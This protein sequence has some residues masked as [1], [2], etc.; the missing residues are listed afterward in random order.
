MDLRKLERELRFAND[1][2]AQMQSPDAG[3]FD[4]PKNPQPHELVKYNRDVKSQTES[5]ERIE[6]KI[7]RI[8][9]EW[10]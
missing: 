2:L 8:K 5:I 7:N 10:N 1:G 3:Y 9:S 6:R 4:D